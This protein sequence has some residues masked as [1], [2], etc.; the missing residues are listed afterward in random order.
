MYELKRNLVTA[1]G[2]YLPKG[3]KVGADEIGG[4]DEVDRLAEK[5][6]IKPVRSRKKQAESVALEPSEDVNNG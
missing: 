2:N 6:W 5:G 3:M 4:Q 1:S